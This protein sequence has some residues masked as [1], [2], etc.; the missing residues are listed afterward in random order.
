MKRTFTKHVF[1]RASVML[2]MT[3]LTSLGAWADEIPFQYDDGKPYLNMQGSVPCTKTLNDASI[4]SFKVYDNGGR[5]GNYYDYSSSTLTITAPEGYLLQLSGWIQTYDNWSDHLTVYDNSEASGTKLIDQMRST[6][7][8]FSRNIPTV[9][10]TGRSMTL[11]FYSNNDG[12]DKGFD[13]DVRLI[14][15]EPH[16]ININTATGGTVGASVSGLSVTSAKVKET[17]TLTATPQSTY[18]LTGISV[19]DG[20][21]KNVGVT[22]DGPFYNTATFTMP[23][24]VATVTPTFTNNL[25]AAGGL[26][27][28]MPKTDSKSLTIPSNVQSFKVYDDGGSTG[29]YSNNC[30]G[31]LVLTAPTGYRMQ[32][33]GRIELYNGYLGNPTFTVYDG[34]NNTASELYHKNGGL[35]S[36]TVTSTGNTMTINLKSGVA[37]TEDDGLDLTVSVFDPDTQNAINGIGNLTG[38]TITASISNESVTSAKAFE[39]VT[40]TATPQSNHMLTG[41]S[42]K[43]SQNNGVGVSWD[44]P[45]DNTATFTMPI[46][47][48]TVTSTFTNDLTADGGLY[49]NMPT[50]GSK[51]LTIPSNVQSFKVYD[52]GG[53]GGGNNN[54]AGN[55]SNGCSG[56][57]TLTAPTGY[58]LQLSG[59]ITTEKDYD[60][61]TVYDGSST[62]G[63][64]LLAAVSSTSRGTE[65]AITTV[66]SSGQSM[67]LYFNS[68]DSRNYAGLDLTVTLISTSTE[69][70]ITVHAATG[71]SVAASVNSSNVSAARVNDVVTLTAAPESGY[72]LSDL[73]VVDGSSNAVA[74]TGGWY[75]NNQ[76]TFTMPASTVTVT[77][78]FTNKW[79]ADGGLYIN[80]PTTGTK[81]VTIPTGVQSFKVY[82]DGGK[83]GNYS[84][85]CDGTLTLTAPTGYVLQLSGSITTMVSTSQLDYLTVYDYNAAC[86]TKLIDEMCSSAENTQTAIPTVFSSSNTMT[87]YFKTNSV[88]NIY[89]GLDLTVTLVRE[90][91]LADN[92]DNTTVINNNNE[93]TTTVTLQGRTLYKD[94][95]WNTLCLPFSMTAEQIALSPLAGATIKELATSSNLNNGTLTLNFEDAT[96]IEAG[97]PYLVKWIDLVIKNKADWEAFAAAVN[98]GNTYEGKVVMLASDFDNS[99]NPVTEEN[100][101]G[102]YKNSNY[103][104]FKGTFD[105]NGRTLTVEITTANNN[106]GPF[107]YVNG[108]TI[109][110]L[111]VAGAITTSNQTAGGIAARVLGGTVAIQNCIS[112][113]AITDNYNKNTTSTYYG[114][115][116]GLIGRINDG[117]VTIS[118]CLFNGQL[119]NG[120]GSNNDGGNGG[121]VG[122]AYA[123][124]LTLTSCLFSPSAAI[125]MNSNNSY[126][127]YRWYTAS[128]YRTKVY[129]KTTFGHANSSTTDASGM[130]NATLLSNLGSGWEISGGNVVPVMSPK[131]PNIVN[132]KFSG[133]TID[134]TAPTAVS[135]TNNASTGDCQFVGNYSPFTI[136]DSNIKSVILLGSNNKLGYSSTNPRTLRCFRAHFFI[137]TTATARSFEL[138]FG[139]DG[140]TTG[141]FQIEN[142]ELKVKTLNSG[143]YTLG[144]LKLQGEPTEKGVYIYNG[145]KVVLK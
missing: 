84:N 13:L 27:I 141:V 137:P 61:L 130:D 115:F 8:G 78:T 144:G 33:S 106:S 68:D 122:N 35:G 31:T 24:S 66:I 96:T 129:Y 131:S 79:T 111:H 117:T 40:L 134:K 97:K 108:A 64:K 98:D 89:A 114:Q 121:F 83:D 136:D 7:G 49:I 41:I 20:S 37:G 34:S 125:T 87:L 71:G 93:V 126:T 116:G 43:D 60:N 105:G 100:M 22:W 23:F 118:N 5:T 140:G 51:S 42:V 92:A 77:P 36:T 81:T 45:F 135:F 124:S 128:A 15:N 1:L 145:K 19:K 95:D 86:G 38:G 46:Y 91:E 143:W 9:T 75:T 94:G 113:V 50:T 21:N 67:T 88:Y 138:N 112:S 53:K 30:D 139:E 62:S 80:M 17:V 127:F 110:N 14:V 103:Y 65:T 133:V 55:Y 29:N 6:S 82:D 52:D 18:M 73:S 2:L 10:S 16:D 142:G 76:A 12:N 63:T 25:T 4:T 120:T 39:A 56:T 32:L 132:P 58:V 101:V 109:K 47:P 44:G 90:V 11:Y 102:T 85:R 59:N 70:A 99:A 123:G 119:L 48:V 72:I 69:Y 74:V 28:N 54:T 57:L 3:M 26:Y 104:P 107:R